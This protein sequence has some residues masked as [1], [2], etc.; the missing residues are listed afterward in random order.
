MICGKL[1]YYRTQTLSYKGESYL[2]VVLT[3]KILWFKKSIIQHLTMFYDW[4]LYKNHWNNLI[5]NELK[6]K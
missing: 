6:Q 4:V 5:Y 3:F 1:L 2:K